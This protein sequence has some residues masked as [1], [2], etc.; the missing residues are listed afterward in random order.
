MS[1]A[2][3]GIRKTN[4]GD[5]VAVVGGKLCGAYSGPGAKASAIREAGTNR[6][7]PAPTLTYPAGKEP[8][9]AR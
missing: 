6:E 3:T 8:V 1:K 2:H 7:L 4:A 9:S 5:W